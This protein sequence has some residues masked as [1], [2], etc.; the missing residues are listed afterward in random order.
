MFEAAKY[1]NAYWFPQQTLET[2]IYLQSNQSI[3]I[4]DANATLM[5]SDKFSSASGA[6]MVHESLQANG[7]LKETPSQ[8]SGCTN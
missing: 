8:G 3:D 5:V 4:A 1:V 6:N 2:A 7:L